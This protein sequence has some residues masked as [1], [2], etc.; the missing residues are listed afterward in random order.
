MS[1]LSPV[2][3]FPAHTGGRRGQPK[4]SPLSEG[5]GRHWLFGWRS[6]AVVFPR[7]HCWLNH[8]L[9][10]GCRVSGSP[11]QCVSWPTRCFCVL[12]SAE[13]WHGHTSCL[14]VGL[15]WNPGLLYGL[16]LKFKSIKGRLLLSQPLYMFIES[17]HIFRVT[18]FLKCLLDQ[19]GKPNFLW[20]QAKNFYK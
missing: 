2:Y 4:I 13:Q 11:S 18:S 6:A 3:W 14:V 17:L 19:E 8:F 10:W 1:P 5:V 20:L 12:F 16:Y 9:I 15:Q 7:L